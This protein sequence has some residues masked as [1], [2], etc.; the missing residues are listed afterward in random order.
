MLVGCRGDSPTTHMVVYY[1]VARM[2]TLNGGAIS[3]RVD[4]KEPVR[5]QN[6]LAVPTLL[7]FRLN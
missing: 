5:T 2:T 3:L 4:V 1:P 7:V 6:T